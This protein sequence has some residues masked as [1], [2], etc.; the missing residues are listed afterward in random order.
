MIF[1]LDKVNVCINFL[2]LFEGSGELEVFA[3][4]EVSLV[5][6]LMNDS[7]EWRRSLGRPVR[8]VYIS[9]QFIPYSTY[10]LPKGN[11]WDLIRQPLFH[12]YWTDCYV[13]F[14][15]QYS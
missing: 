1:H 8:S 3:T 10:A 9:C 14:N 12:V 4:L 6:D 2:F 15:L 11:Q 13:R 5:R 7:C